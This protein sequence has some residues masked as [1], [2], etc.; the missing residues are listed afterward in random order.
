MIIREALIDL[1]GTL[2]VGDTAVHGAVDAIET[3]QQS[4][5]GVT[6]LTNTSTKSSTELLEQLKTIG[7]SIDRDSLLTSVLAT[8]RYLLQNKLRP[9]CLMED[10]SDL[11]P[12][13]PVVDDDGPPHN[14]VVVGLAPSHFHYERLNQAFRLLLSGDVPLIAIHRANYLRDGDGDLSLGPGG[15]VT[16]L[17]HASDTQAIVMGKPSAE[18][19]AS[20][21]RGDSADDVVMVGDDW[22]QDILGAQEA[23]IGHTVLV[24][25]GKYREGD[26]DKCHPSY[27][28]ESI[29]EAL[30]YILKHSQP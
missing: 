17:E 16:C 19:F 18:F 11:S 21:I 9:L 20:A 13:V 7:F 15:F 26:E 12:E 8:K 25:T 24:K 4:S 23:G 28:A 22:K 6:F 14:A 27:L 3:L 5:I 29:V 2:H 10:T 30:E 1:S